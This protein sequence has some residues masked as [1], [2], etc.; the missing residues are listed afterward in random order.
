MSSITPR[1]YMGDELLNYKSMDCYVHFVSGW[2]REI[3]VLAPPS[4]DLRVV[5]SKVSSLLICLL[6]ML[7]CP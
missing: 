3:L 1:T 2:V 4:E 6:S 5:I 7:Y